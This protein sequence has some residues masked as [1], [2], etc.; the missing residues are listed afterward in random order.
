MCKAIVL[1]QRSKLF[2]YFRR[3]IW[4]KRTAGHWHCPSTQTER[5]R[6]R[7]AALHEAPGRAL[8]SIIRIYS[9]YLHTV[10][11]CAKELWIIDQLLKLIHLDIACVLFWFILPVASQRTLRCR[12]RCLMGRNKHRPR[13]SIVRDSARTRRGTRHRPALERLL[14]TSHVEKWTFEQGIHR[15]S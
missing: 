2:N 4:Y 13:R 7:V 11:L 9:H 6:Q 8:V 10:L 5:W 14:F 1:T 3:Y 12:P 15:F